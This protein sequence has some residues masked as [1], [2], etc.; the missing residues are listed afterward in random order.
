[1][2]HTHRTGRHGPGFTLIELMVTLGISALLAA[3]G[4]PL[5]SRQRATAAVSVAANRTLS[6]LQAARQQALT[7]GH[8]VTV[9]PSPDEHHC[10]FGG[11]QWMV[12]ANGTGG[13]DSTRESGEPLLGLWQMPTGVLATGTR[14]YAAFQPSARSATTLTL[15]FCHAGHPEITRSVIVSQTGRPRLSRPTLASNQRVRGCP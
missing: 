2:R 4:W 13:V 5:L 11:T 15:R 14:G 3:V 7:T 1:M 8:A 9:C 12:F 10:G 6:A